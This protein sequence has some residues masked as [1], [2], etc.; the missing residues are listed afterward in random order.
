VRG[1][2]APGL[3]EWTGTLGRVIEAE[4]GRHPALP[5]LPL[6]LREALSY[7]LPQEAGRGNWR[8]C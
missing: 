6:A 5:G 4:A 8:T 2:P 1:L 3:A 7:E